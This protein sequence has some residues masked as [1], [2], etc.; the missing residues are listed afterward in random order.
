MQIV[1][2][3]GPTAKFWVQYLKMVSLMNRF[4]EAE[5]SGN[6]KLHLESIKQML[7]FFHAAGHNNYAKSANVYLQDMVVLHE[8]MSPLKLEQYT[9]QGFFYPQKN[10]QVLGRCVVGHDDR[11][12][13]YA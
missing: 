11:T 7:P 4:I 8:Q 3:I 13:A 10:G 5:R 9:T 2:D 6:W 1:S 12:N